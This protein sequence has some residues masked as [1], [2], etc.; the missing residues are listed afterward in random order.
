MSQEIVKV[1]CE[2]FQAIHRGRPVCVEGILEP[3]LDGKIYLVLL[4]NV[5]HGWVCILLAFGLVK[6]M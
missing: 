4:C 6:K 3:S 5:M 2:E 1:L